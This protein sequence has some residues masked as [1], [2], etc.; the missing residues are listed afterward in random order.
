MDT[1]YREALTVE[2][3]VA[4]PDSLRRAQILQ[5]WAGTL[6]NLGR[7]D[8]TVALMRE[9]GATRRDLKSE[10]DPGFLYALG[11]LPFALRDTGHLEESERVYREVIAGQ[12]A[13]GPLGRVD[14]PETLNNLA[15]LLDSDLGRHSAAEPL[16]RE[17]IRLHGDLY[18]HAHLMMLR[19]RGNLS[20][21]LMRDGGSS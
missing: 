17:A 14:L 12:W 10:E 20:G 15:V 1:L 7:A 9:A 19:Y 8:S 4:Q 2:R 16:Y 13:L 3:R 21:A 5:A 11:Q 18:A 6:R